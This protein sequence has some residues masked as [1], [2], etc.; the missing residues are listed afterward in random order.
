[1]IY[2]LFVLCVK[3]KLYIMKKIPI[4]R[5]VYMT[6]RIYNI[7][8]INQY[9]FIVKSYEDEI[10]YLTKKIKVRLN[11]SEDIYIH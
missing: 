5:V 11:K 4:D 7:E 3:N 6:K 8:N 2:N 9:S 1:M 10:K